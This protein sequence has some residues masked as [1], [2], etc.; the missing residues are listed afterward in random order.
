VNGNVSATVVNLDIVKLVALSLIVG[1]AGPIVLTTIQTQLVSA[2]KLQNFVQ[3]ALNQTDQMAQ[4]LK[5]SIPNAVNSAIN[6]HLKE[7][8]PLMR[9]VA[10]ETPQGIVDLLKSHE[11][12]NAD[13]TVKDNNNPDLKV[14]NATSPENHLSGIQNILNGIAEEAEKAL[15]NDINQNINDAKKAIIEASNVSGK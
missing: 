8:E 12:I 9:Q 6:N 13:M 15:H 4:T 1:S 7:F 3:T 2:L 5:Q 14:I 10:E 11:L